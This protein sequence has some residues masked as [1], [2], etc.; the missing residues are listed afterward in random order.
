M[1]CQA[2]K[3]NQIPKKKI[4]K[5]LA[6]SFWVFKYTLKELRQPRRA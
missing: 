2:I 3:K 1:N 5:L 4:N 6:V